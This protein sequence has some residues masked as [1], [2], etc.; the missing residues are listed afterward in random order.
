[1][2]SPRR[3][4]L[5]ARCLPAVLLAAVALASL[6]AVALGAG[7]PFPRP[8]NG[9]RVYD[10]AG[11]F[12]PDTIS[13]VQA[14]IDRIEERTG[15]QVVVYT[16]GVEAGRTTEEADNDARSL[17]DQWGVGRKGFDDGLV[18]LFDMYPGNEHGQV[19]LYGG[20]GFRATFLDNAEKQRIFDED[21][22]PLLRNGNVD[23]ALLVAMRRVDEA[24]TPEHAATLERAR[25]VDAVL[26]LL[27]APMLFVLVVGAGVWS[28][29]R[30]GRDP[31]YL[32]DPSILMAGPPE[33]LT[34][35]DAVFILAGHATRRALT[36][37]MLDLASRGR[38]AFR[39]EHGLF[40]MNKKVGI[41]TQPPEPDATTLARQR[42][43]DVRA[44]GPA[45][46]LA[47]RRIKAVKHDETGYIEPDDL[48]EFGSAV[49]A[50]DKALE[51]EVVRR[52]WFGKKP[53]T[54]VAHWVG[55]GVIIAV[56]GCLAIF[57][58]VNIPFN[59]LLFIGIALLAAGIATIILAQV[60]PAVTFSGAMIRA[61]LAAYRR[62]LKK[63]MDQARSMDQVVAEAGLTW[64]E[65]PDQA[66]VWGT[67]LG[68]HGE[69][70]GV[71]ARS[72][73][74][75]R[76]GRVAPGSV[77]APVWYATGPG[78]G[79]A[80]GF[81]GGDFAGSGSGSGSVFSSS[82]V[83]NLGGMMAAL[84]TIGNSPASSGSGGGGGFGGGGSGGGGG[85]SGGGF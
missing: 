33:A 15:A 60:M 21:M 6:A 3:R 30:F 36:T 83:P 46:D 26:G 66:V 11:I 59:G 56:L 75:Q 22:L 82:A 49:P 4:Q 73:E 78:P 2:P 44:L 61:M 32:D 51:A 64:L 39:E 84:G 52:G 74:D 5:L 23:E 47:E 8:E 13:Q 35:A 62:T 25:Q 9:V 45:E 28:W 42:R 79:G 85:G 63:T 53:S 54:V 29:R 24:T 71:L 48:L 38:I 57:G 40:G 31:V 70:E 69:I 20:P 72:V 41:E 65:T 27:V 10:T 81:A 34:P 68:L 76:E 55:R 77:W 37:A 18:I 80:A 14:T 1:M 43:N 19:I 58:G 67:A 50:F 17:M 7:P 16:Q 12:R